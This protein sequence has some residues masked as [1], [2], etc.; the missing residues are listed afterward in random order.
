LRTDNYRPVA[1]EEIE[2]LRQRVRARARGD[3]ILRL[4]TRTYRVD[5]DIITALPFGWGQ[6]TFALFQL[7]ERLQQKTSK[8]DLPS[9]GGNPDH[10]DSPS[11][12]E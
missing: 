12:I 7:L 9:N 6:I 11:V 8:S 10:P 4:G 3:V 1:R 5:R 2:R